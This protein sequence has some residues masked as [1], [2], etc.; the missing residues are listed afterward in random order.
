VD[1]EMTDSDLIKMKSWRY[2]ST[3]GWISPEKVL[4]STSDGETVYKP[5]RRG[6]KRRKTGEDSGA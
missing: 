4:T 5:K 2:S 3:E 6:R 1:F